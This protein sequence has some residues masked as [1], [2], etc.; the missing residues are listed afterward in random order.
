MT[1]TYYAGLTYMVDYD[2]VNG[3]VH[4]QFTLGR[5][6]TADRGPLEQQHWAGHGRGV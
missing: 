1:R 6:G 3:S 5:M 4:Q 2:N